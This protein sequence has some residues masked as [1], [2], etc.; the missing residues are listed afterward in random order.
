[1]QDHVYLG[2]LL[3]F[4]RP[5]LSEKQRRVLAMYLEED[6]SLAEIAAQ[7]GISRQAVHDALHRGE[8]TLTEMEGEMHLLARYRAMREALL[9]C[10]ALAEADS[11]D[12]DA[13]RV[14]I[15]EALRLW[16]GEEADG[17]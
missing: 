8:A 3:Q 1:M 10:R 17:I 5:V 9:A 4:Y 6:L 2:W 16:E 12:R 11:L 14:Q 13:L 7:T 15:D